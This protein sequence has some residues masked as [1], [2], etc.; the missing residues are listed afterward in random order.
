MDIISQVPRMIKQKSAWLNYGR[1]LSTYGIFDSGRCL[2]RIST[3]NRY[4]ADTVIWSIPQIETCPGATV[5]C[6]QVCYANKG[7]C[8][9]PSVKNSR[10]TNL[11]FTQRDDFIP[12]M[13][14]LIEKTGLKR[15]RIHEA[16][17]FYSLDYAKKWLAIAEQM[18]DVRFW[19][20]SRSWEV[21]DSLPELPGN[22]K[23]R[24]SVDSTTNHFPKRE[25][26]RAYMGEMAGVLMCQAKREGSG[27]LCGI[28]RLCLETDI[29]VWF[30]IH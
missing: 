27:I 7:Y 1:I 30:P 29:P 15:V 11:V 22:L 18:P 10:W 28:C 9:S 24:Y 17:D 13:I 19:T 2:A 8:H 26:S 16:G 12:L 3:G 6:R 21:L 23:I 14:R 5:A 20:Y 4:I 25:Y